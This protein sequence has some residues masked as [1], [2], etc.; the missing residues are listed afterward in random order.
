[1]A[2]AII[3]FFL[4]LLTPA[5]ILLGWMYDRIHTRAG[6]IYVTVTFAMA[7]ILLQIPDDEQ[8]MWI[9]SILFAFGISSGTVSPSFITGELF[10]TKEFGILFGFVYAVCMGA[11]A[12]ANPL[13]AAINDLTSSYNLAWSACMTLCLLSGVCIYYAY[14]S[15]KNLLKKRQKETA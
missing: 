15:Y 5:K 11:M 14:I 9:M 4:F 3:P 8:L 13:L 2:H 7:F 6:T 10:G 1:M 12:V